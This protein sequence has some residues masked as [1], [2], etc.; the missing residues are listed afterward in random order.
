MLCA[1]ATAQVAIPTLDN[2][3]MDETGI[4]TN[5][6]RNALNQ[7][8]MQFEAD[9][10]SQIAVLIIPTLDGEDIVDYTVRVI[11]DWQLGRKNIDDSVLLFVALNDRKMRI[12]VGDGLEGAIPDLAAMMILED[13]LMPAFRSENYGAGIMAAVDDIIGKIQGEALPSISDAPLE[14]VSENTNSSLLWNIFYGYLVVA[15]IIF[16]IWPILKKYR[17]N[18]RLIM[19]AIIT[20]G[21][22]V[23]YF[24]D[25]GFTTE[26]HFNL[27]IDYNRLAMPSWLQNLLNNVLPSILSIL[28]LISMFIALALT[29][30]LLFLLPFRLSKRRAKRTEEFIQFPH[31]TGNHSPIKYQRANAPD[32]FQ[33]VATQRNTQST[34]AYERT[35]ERINNAKNAGTQRQKN[36]S[37]F[38]NDHYDPK[39]NDISHSISTDLN[40]KIHPHSKGGSGK[41][42]NESS[43]EAH[44]RFRREQMQQHSGMSESVHSQQGAAHTRDSV[45]YVKTTPSLEV[46]YDAEQ[47]QKAPQQPAHLE[48][49]IDTR[50]Q[51]PYGRYTEDQAIQNQSSTN[52]AEKM[53]QETS[54]PAN[55]SPWHSPPNVVDTSKNS[56]ARKLKDFIESVENPKSSK[57]RL[58]NGFF[59]ALFIG[60][61]FTIFFTI[62]FDGQFLI[63]LGIGVATFIYQFIH[64]GTR[65]SEGKFM[66]AVFK[67]MPSSAIV[68]L[69]A[70]FT[71]GLSMG[72]MI[73]GGFFVFQTLG[74]FTGILKAPIHINM[75]K[76]GSIGG[77]RGRSSS[78]GSSRSSSS[79]SSSSSSGRSGGGGRSSGGGASGGW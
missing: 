34:D 39:L 73:G 65:I 59:A 41:S 20:L 40:Q 38:A 4:L 57:K 15:G 48:A 26:N 52:V 19:I 76:G 74:L 24:S 6:E 2:G 27:G 17:Q 18:P 22:I 11:E 5:S 23:W 71:A 30:I 77:G 3:V 13:H 62:F 1:F 78:S 70:T 75:G 33:Q 47:N 58:Q 66:G 16:I 46:I 14:P 43:W 61:F 51:H 56:P 72:L 12:E 25:F 7:K 44:R 54:S 42:N 21:A 29:P 8:I 53:T 49:G 68:A 31:T 69:F 79:S 63:G 45:K 32:P 50:K 36:E 28:L 9:T 67:S 35:I 55:S 64:R 37:E 10:G 60:F